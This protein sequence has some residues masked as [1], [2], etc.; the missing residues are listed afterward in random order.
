M[1][2]TIICT[3]AFEPA[4]FAAPGAVSTANATVNLDVDD[5]G[6]A[7]TADQARTWFE[8][9]LA[10]LP[11][12][13]YFLFEVAGTSQTT[14][15]VLVGD[16]PV[17]P[18]GTDLP[19]LGEPILRWLDIRVASGSTWI[20]AAGVEP[21]Y[22]KLSASQLLR[23]GQGWDAPLPQNAG[24]SRSLKLEV[25]VSGGP[26]VL[27]PY[28]GDAEPVSPIGVQVEREGD[29]DFYAFTY[30]AGL[31]FAVE[32]RASRIAVPAADETLLVDE[33]TGFLLVREDA[34]ET[35]QALK[36]I[37]ERS[38]SLMW[39]APQLLGV[40]WPV[41]EG[42]S[43][44]HD[45]TRLIRRLVW[46]AVVAMTTMLDPVVTA[47]T[48]AGTLREGPFIA[49]LN[50]IVENF[51]LE[52]T[53]DRLDSAGINAL[54]TNAILAGVAPG[55]EEQPVDR[56]RYSDLLAELFK[57]DRS[58][59]LL[60]VLL[61]IY[62]DR[63]LGAVSPAE[64][65]D[66]L[67][68]R[69]DPNWD[70][71]RK[72]RELEEWLDAELG[73]LI[74][75]IESE[76]GIEA[77]ALHL[78][79]R[80]GLA[81]NSFETVLAAANPGI[82]Q[83]AAAAAQIRTE[84]ERHLESSF[85]GLDAARF[86]HGSLVQA[87]IQP[88][89]HDWGKAQV[90]G[91]L[92]GSAWF[93]K[94][95]GLVE[96]GVSPPL[97]RLVRNLGTVGHGLLDAPD[98]SA[99]AARLDRS[100]ADVC[101]SLFGTASA[102]RRFVPDTLPRPLPVRIAVD[103]DVDDIDGFAIR[104]AGVA[105]LVKRDEAAGRGAE[106]PWAYANLAKVGE[107]QTQGEPDWRDEITVHPLLPVAIDGQSATFLEYDGNPVAAGD[108][109]PKPEATEEMQTLRPFFAYRAPD[110]EE[111]AADGKQL[112]P[113]LGYGYDYSVASHAV[114]RSGALP[115]A[116]AAADA[117]WLPGNDAP[118]PPPETL[119]KSFTKTFPYRRTTAIGRI[120]TAAKDERFGALAGVDPLSRDYPRLGFQAPAGGEAL[121]DLWRNGDGGGSLPLPAEDG[122]ALTICLDD[123]RAFG[124]GELRVSVFRSPTADPDAAAAASWDLAVAGPFDHRALSI[125]VTRSGA[126]WA[127][128]LIA[129]GDG[130][131]SLQSE[132]TVRVGDAADLPPFFWLRL[133]G[134]AGAAIMSV[135]YS[136][137][138]ARSVAGEAAQPGS[139]SLLL[140]APDAGEMWK[141]GLSRQAELTVSFPRMGYVDFDRWLNNPALLAR[142]E[143]AKR[144]AAL[145][146]WLLAS[147]LA[148][149]DGEQ[150]WS[151]I[152]DLA[153]EKL[154]V[155]LTP[156]D[157]LLPAA[158]AA[159]SLSDR[160][161][162][163][164]PLPRLG[165]TLGDP[166][167][168][169][170]WVAEQLKPLD[171]IYSAKL[172]ITPGRK[173]EIKPD[174][175]R[176]W[177]VTVPA[178][179]VARLTLRPMVPATFF[180]EGITGLPIFD[181]DYLQLALDRVDD[182]YVF[183]GPSQLIEVMQQLQEPR[184]PDSM[185]WEALAARQVIVLPSGRQRTYDLA[186]RA[187]PLGE[188]TAPWR[189]LSAIEVFTQRW[190]FL[191]RPIQ[192]WFDP[193]SARLR[194]PIDPE[195]A[196]STVP[197][198][199]LDPDHKDLIRFEKEAFLG[200][201]EQDGDVYSARL[202]PLPL[203]GALPSHGSSTV[204]QSFPWEK[205]SATMFRHR[206][207]LR[208][209]YAG[210]MRLA[211]N[212]EVAV[213]RPR[214][215]RAD[216]W[217][218]VVMLA[219]RSKLQLTRPQLRAL[220]PLT[221]SPEP[222]GTP[223]VLAMLEE[224][225]FAHAGLA[226]RIGAEVKTGFA[227]EMRRATDDEGDEERLEIADSRKEFGKDP[228]LTYAAF[229][230]EAASA[231][232]L[233]PEGPVGLTFDSESAPAPAFANT[234]WLLAP[235][236]M[237][238]VAAAANPDLEE[239]FLSV[240]LRRYTDHRW[241]VDS[242]AE[243]IPGPPPLP[244]PLAASETWWVEIEDTAVLSCATA[245]VDEAEAAPPPV[246]ICQLQKE[247]GTW[248]VMVRP[249]AI[250]PSGS[251]D[252]WCPV[253]RAD[254]SRTRG[255]RLLYQPLEE[256]RA[257]LSVFAEPLGRL[258][259]HDGA[260][261]GDQPVMLTSFEWT[262]SNPNA[263]HR[264][265]LLLFDRVVEAHRVSAS[266]ATV[267]NWT[268]TGRN[269]DILYTADGTDLAPV[270]ASD[271]V[272][273]RAG[274]ERGTFAASDGSATL[275]PRP[276]LSAE[277]NPLHVH[278]QLGMILTRE[279]EGLGRELEIFDPEAYL[280]SG[281]I[282]PLP[283]KPA[284]RRR[285]RLVELEMP[286]QPVCGNTVLENFPAA[287]FDL[288]AVVKQSY[289]GSGGPAAGLL[290]TI[291]LLG[292]S[293]TIRSGWSLKMA[294]R[295]GRNPAV[296]IELKQIGGTETFNAA[297]V[298]L[299]VPAQPP[300]ARIAAAL[301]GEDGVKHDLGAMGR[302]IETLRDHETVTLEEFEIGHTEGGAVTEWWA[303]VSMLVL[304]HWTAD[305]GRLPLSFDWLFT[306]TGGS[307]S[308]SVTASALSRMTEAEAR[309]VAVSPAI[310]V[311]EG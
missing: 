206:L 292:Q 122:A 153:V 199:H 172:R 47:L 34:E 141:D 305:L 295:F 287:C 29:Q 167:Q 202:N 272:L 294:L 168:V 160:R 42:A 241:S 240:S 231:L 306:G 48:M 144:V 186:V 2:A 63:W 80:F 192:N 135:S 11:T 123:I 162:L 94:R 18:V 297:S 116:I 12:A 197:V 154:L 145:R 70:S 191:G 221:S 203:P 126:G 232:T 227:Y 271:L 150:I 138:R 187:D 282:V 114:S 300:V 142:V 50:A 183:D 288:P 86:A 117:P 100:F 290:F 299:T 166:A 108:L 20:T 283:A 177:T 3:S 1:T 255:L 66:K 6:A 52:G 170:N 103:R 169:R 174:S 64:F 311:E 71:A 26:W 268:R 84:F 224:H 198:I 214:A 49:A 301:I 293:R 149:V 28:F 256:G 237:T 276:R 95:T 281:T 254:G 111:L 302:G 258:A 220:L 118:E 105:L 106:S 307:A 69:L 35:H 304:P 17:E 175:D 163:I 250:L 225:P 164:V 155:E 286:A 60:P 189:Q 173:L 264:V 181:R 259:G 196:D 215:D 147:R 263:K 246:E 137:P 45:R 267:M 269:F 25:G 112:L 67:K 257:A 134:R 101:D 119:A 204:L 68:E 7:T 32:G 139:D 44:E 121:A 219:D 89:G 13:R 5:T 85:N 180:G 289:A 185:S 184:I 159:P 284:A 252:G 210:A 190:R 218:R 176:V 46:R 120:T 21:D 308:E 115:G 151:R 244:Y 74:H 266:P 260:V 99:L 58:S 41:G 24:L 201:D 249:K 82:P 39:T 109:G 40:E 9:F 285:A 107:P 193:K 179:M 245:Q 217:I 33:E 298:L 207:V 56:K 275:W 53:D 73:A 127:F 55:H 291:R 158:E 132:E 59:G 223:P 248:T 8:A 81:G 247:N 38:A 212:G 19:G 270:L 209:R 31:G 230:P 296:P 128:R 280:L 51:E 277:R 65:E 310:P 36:R 102:H 96:L 274:P 200:R 194:P 37:R 273:K 72:A 87:L 22:R 234:A 110:A 303:D 75:R 4:A 62:A 182:H 57:L 83:A 265:D 90:E 262:I 233:V 279:A 78:I 195:P 242:D 216:R 309:I 129:P 261:A 238:S 152:P 278:R 124:S 136:D 131:L 208:S 77:L 10:A 251:E 205:P 15:L 213:H 43:V 235:R 143:T 14:Q 243:R 140:L 97:E 125:E 222:G 148:G 92:R 130:S 16:Q 171:D 226:D 93:T 229:E 178:G 23:W 91:I 76:A 188:E 253:A 165:D 79:D 30:E 104:Y 27:I 98:R 156:V 133:R 113:A 228:R 61:S 239:H 88:P 161:R 54:I 146:R 236:F 157:S 211:G